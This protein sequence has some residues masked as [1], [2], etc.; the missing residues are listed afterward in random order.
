MSLF[1]PAGLLMPYYCWSQQ[2]HPLGNQDVRYLWHLQSLPGGRVCCH[3]W[4]WGCVEG[5]QGHGCLYCDRAGG[6][7]GPTTVGTGGRDGVLGTSEA[8]PMQ[9]Q[10][11]WSLLLSLGA[12]DSSA[13]RELLLSLPSPTPPGS[14]G[15][16]L[17]GRSTAYCALP[18]PPLC[19]PRRPPS[20]GQTWVILQHRSALHR[21]TFAELQI[22]QLV[23]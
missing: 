1:V 8:A 18:R 4:G 2:D 3:W 19:V 13:A 12:G 16:R 10:A 20:D 22:L 11:P 5:G 14:L 23:D 17:W 9:L 15:L 21:R 6:C 7:P